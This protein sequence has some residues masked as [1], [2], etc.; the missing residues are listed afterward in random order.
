MD[1]H[2]IALV[3]DVWMIF[4]AFSTW[5]CAEIAIL[6]YVYIWFGTKSDSHMITIVKASHDDHII[7]SKCLSLCWWCYCYHKLCF[8]VDGVPPLTWAGYVNFI[9]Y[10]RE[11]NA[12]KFDGGRCLF[13]PTI[14]RHKP[15]LVKAVRHCTSSLM[16][17]N[18]MVKDVRLARTIRQQRHGNSHLFW[19][20]LAELPVLIMNEPSFAGAFSKQ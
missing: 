10:L 6:P 13:T 3:S 19:R 5:F 2:E 20:T 8:T 14:G 12:P 9:I 15:W 1:T 11:L 17:W 18:A 7:L 16:R 4:M